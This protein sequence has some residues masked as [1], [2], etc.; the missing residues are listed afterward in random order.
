MRK[1][2]FLAALLVLATP[3]AFAADDIII[4]KAWARAS[5]TQTAENGVVYMT[6]YNNNRRADVLTGVSGTVANKIE[7][8]NMTFNNGV[9]RM[10]PAGDL[11]I[12][13]KKDTLLK[14]NGYHIMLMGLKAPLIRD[15]TFKLVLHFQNAGDVETEVSIRAAKTKRN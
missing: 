3:A 7:V 13:S 11:V 9:M 10:F 15:E 4:K 14:P 1:V 6:I 8:H 12:P 5:L 2:L